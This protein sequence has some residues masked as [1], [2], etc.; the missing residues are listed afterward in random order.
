MPTVSFFTDDSGSPYYRADSDHYV[1]LGLWL[2]MDLSS[3]Y[4]RCLGLLSM[5]DDVAAG[6]SASEEW[7]G[8][9]FDATIT[10]AG[11]ALR[12]NYQPS[13]RGRYSLDEVRAAAED[14]WSYLRGRGEGGAIRSFRP[15]L[16]E[17]LADL[18]MWEQEWGPHPYRGR[19]D[20]P[21]AGPA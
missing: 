13:R 9:G 2:I 21:A 10:K 4:S 17:Y 12:D 11:V 5:V 20:I 18:L 8:E 19:L 16:P 6:R 1:P 3:S 14:Y 7:E 15:D